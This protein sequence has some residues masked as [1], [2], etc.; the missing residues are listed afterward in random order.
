MRVGGFNNVERAVQTSPALYRYPS[1]I[2]EQKK[3][4]ELLA[5]EFGRLQT[6]GNNSQQ[7]MQRIPQ[8]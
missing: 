4:R 1:A 3:R 2:T 8:A 5:Q 7:H 6:L